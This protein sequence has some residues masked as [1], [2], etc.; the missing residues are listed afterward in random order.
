V[1][2]L[3]VAGERLSPI[4]SSDRRLHFAAPSCYAFGWFYEEVTL[5]IV[6]ELTVIALTIAFFALFDLYTRGCDRI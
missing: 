6:L 5:M 3:G 2:G 1:R 4:G